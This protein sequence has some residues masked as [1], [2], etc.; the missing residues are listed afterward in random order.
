MGFRKNAKRIVKGIVHSK[1]AKHLLKS[2][3]FSVITDFQ[4]EPIPI[5]IVEG[6]FDLAGPGIVGGFNFESRNSIV[7]ERSFETK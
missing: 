2:V 6:H 1:Y 5:T 3:H 4:I 7:E